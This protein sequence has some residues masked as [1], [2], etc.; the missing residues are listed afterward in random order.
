MDGLTVVE[1]WL[2]TSDGCGGSSSVDD[3]GE[4]FTLNC[5]VFFFFPKLPHFT[6]VVG[7]SVEK[8]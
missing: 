6:D 3:V 8:D 4:G 5:K 1:W 7:V 2:A